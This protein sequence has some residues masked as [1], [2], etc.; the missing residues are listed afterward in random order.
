MG[1]AAVA[2]GPPLSTPTGSLRMWTATVFERFCCCA[3]ISDS[4]GRAAVREGS[5]SIADDPSRRP[6]GAACPPGRSAQ[7]LSLRT[8]W[9]SWCGSAGLPR[10][11]IFKLSPCQNA[12]LVSL[13]RRPAECEL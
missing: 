10:R 4:E 2:T 1:L 7:P 11:K 3:S 8:E 13:Q 5:R 12:S 9:S 6:L